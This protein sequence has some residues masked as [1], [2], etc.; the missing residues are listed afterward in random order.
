MC[1]NFAGI[2]MSHERG[3]GMLSGLLKFLSAH[4]FIV[5]IEFLVIML[6][7]M[8]PQLLKTALCVF[9]AYRA[10]STLG[11]AARVTGG[12]R[13]I[14]LQGRKVRAPHESECLLTAGR[15]DPIDSATENN[16][17]V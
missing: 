10:A 14:Y 15:G 1:T 17:P 16:P 11:C 7:V 12:R 8:K 9:H 2:W 4:Y 6:S 13:C 3:A 5:G